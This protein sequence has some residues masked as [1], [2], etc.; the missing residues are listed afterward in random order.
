LNFV[1]RR[2][3]FWWDRR[4]RLSPSVG[5][6]IL[7]AAAFSGGASVLFLAQVSS[8]PS[9]PPA[10]DTSAERG[11]PHHSTKPIAALGGDHFLTM[12]DRIESA[13]SIPFYREAL[14]GLSIAKSTRAT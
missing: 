1:A 5:Q 7:P 3:D 2:A 13:A 9:P 11:K 14:S 6:A 4:F 8:S 10:A 12:Q